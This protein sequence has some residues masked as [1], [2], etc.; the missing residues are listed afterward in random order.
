MKLSKLLE[1]FYA[2]VN[3]LKTELTEDEWELLRKNLDYAL[4]QVESQ[5]RLVRAD[6]YI[7][8]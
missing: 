5:L 3:Q 6:K 2:G 4:S 8:E 1:D 7:D